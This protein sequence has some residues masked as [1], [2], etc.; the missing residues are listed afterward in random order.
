MVRART[1]TAAGE[2][3]SAAQRQ[4]E[5]DNSTSY[6]VIRLSIL[7]VFCAFAPS[8]KRAVLIR[9]NRRGKDYGPSQDGEVRQSGLKQSTARGGAHVLT[10]EIGTRHDFS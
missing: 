1:R 2:P 10:L 5:L 8:L 7:A 6:V 4:A 3:Y 9:P